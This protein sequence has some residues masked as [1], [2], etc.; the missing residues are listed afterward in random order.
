MQGVFLSVSL[1]HGHAFLLIVW[2]D[3]ADP[4]PTFN[5]FSM[6]HVTEQKLSFKDFTKCN[7]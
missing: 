2:C 6:E 4:C 3:G 1:L 7:K 5:T